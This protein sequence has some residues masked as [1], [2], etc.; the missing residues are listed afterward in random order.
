M[1]EKNE[2][3]IKHINSEEDF[4]KII[5]G[6]KP[7]LVDFFADW[8]GP[9]KMMAPILEDMTETYKSIEKV[10][11]AKV[12]IDEVKTLAMEYGI[13]SI[14]TFMFFKD[15]KPVEFDGE[16]LIVGMRS[17]DDLV[18]KFDSLI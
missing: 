4:K 3:K 13:M 8:C 10:E 18:A 1:A 16:N 14:P 15:G 7:V 11:I 5:N 6:G 12:D 2:E 9:C 17:Q